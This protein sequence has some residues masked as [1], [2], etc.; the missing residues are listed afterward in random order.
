MKKWALTVALIAACSQVNAKSSSNYSSLY[1]F[2][3]H[4]NPHIET[5]LLLTNDKKTLYG[6]RA[7]SIYKYSRDSGTFELIKEGGRAVDGSYYSYEGHLTLSKNNDYLY[8]AKIAGTKH[9]AIYRINLRTLEEEILHQFGDYRVEG[10]IPAGG[11]VLDAEEK[12][13]YG[14]TTAGG[15]GKGTN[16]PWSLGVIFRIAL[17]GTAPA[18]QVLHYFE[19]DENGG[20]PIGSLA[21][22]TNGKYLYGITDKKGEKNCGTIFKLTLDEAN[23][24]PI[25]TLHSFDCVQEGKANELIASKDSRFLYGT[26]YRNNWS[27]NAGV[28]FRMDTRKHTFK[29]IHQFNKED[30]FLPTG[31]AMSTNEKVLYGATR[32]N[33]YQ[34]A[35]DNDKFDFTRIFDFK[36]REPEYIQVND[37]MVFD[38]SNNSLYGT[39]ASTG[40]YYKGAIFQLA[41]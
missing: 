13:I 32:K 6:H 25:N 8:G 23:Q 11:L 16:D 17:T 9:G 34:I 28:A 2:K 22:S 31:L 15:A 38:E 33:I 29:I 18:F 26:A 10:Y 19:G 36:D 3:D 35:I 24:F 40:S 21:L 14:V 20:A 30:G 12:Y 27:N 1:Y 4:Y 5:N 39:T 41:L 37:M 7:Y